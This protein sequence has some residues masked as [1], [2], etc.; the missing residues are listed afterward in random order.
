MSQQDLLGTF[1]HDYYLLKK[2]TKHTAPNETNQDDLSLLVMRIK[3]RV[4]GDHQG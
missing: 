4:F 1:D 3:L 2:L